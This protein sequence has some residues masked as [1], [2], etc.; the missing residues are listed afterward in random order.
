MKSIEVLESAG[1]RWTVLGKG[2]NLLV[3]DAGWRGA[4]I[5]LGEDFS[6]IDIDADEACVRAGAAALSARVL[7]QAASAG[8][9]GSGSSDDFV[10]RSI[11]RR[12]NSVWNR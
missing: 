1:V 11:V 6:K 3:A 5:Y 10:V 4:V 9:G 7:A 2:T 8:G 12:P